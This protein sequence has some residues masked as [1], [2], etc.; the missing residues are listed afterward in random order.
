MTAPPPVVLAIIRALDGLSE[1][2]GKL[3]A[4]LIIPMVLAL[5]YEVVARYFFD[6]PTVWAYDM[7]FILYGSH[8]M[9]GIAYTLQKGGHIRTDNFYGQWSVRRQGWVDTICYVV[10]FFPCLIIFFIVTVQF[11][12]V[13]F[14]QGERVVT[15]PWMPIIWPLKFVIPLAIGLLLLQGVSELMKS[16]W[17]A[18]KGERL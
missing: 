3:F 13:S 6:A 10:F 17:A 15:S 12:L 18:L 11:F 16:V 1:W 14:N 8:F 4:W 5:T 9:L 2:S 7:T